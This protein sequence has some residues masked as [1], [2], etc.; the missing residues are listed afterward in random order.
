MIDAQDHELLISIADVD[1][2]DDEEWH[3]WKADL[4]RAM[5]DASVSKSRSAN[6]IEAFV[7]E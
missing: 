3:A 5:H 7:G 4:V 6:T 2:I 1:A